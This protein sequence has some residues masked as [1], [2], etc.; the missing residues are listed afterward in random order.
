MEVEQVTLNSNELFSQTNGECNLNGGDL[1]AP[2]G[3]SLNGGKLNGSGNIQGDVVNDG[4]IVSPGHSPGAIT[5]SGNYTQTANGTLNLQIAGTARRNAIRPTRHHGH[6][7]LAGTLNLE[8]LNGFLPKD[9][10]NFQLLTYYNAVGTWANYTGFSPDPNVTFTRTQTPAYFIATAHVVDVTPPTVSIISPSSSGLFYKTNPTVSGTAADESSGSGLASDD[11]SDVSLRCYGS[12]GRILEWLDMGY[13]YNAA[14]HER[15]T[16]G[17][18]ASWTFTL[19]TLADGKYY[20]RATAKDKTGNKA[21]S[22]S[23]D[24]FVDK[25]IPTALTVTAP[26]ASGWV[27]SLNAI[28]GTATDATNSSGIDNVELILQR[29]SDNKYWA[30][31]G[32]VSNS[33]VIKSQFR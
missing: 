15:A 30:D 20:V 5:I 2:N 32:W 16:S 4:G 27:K 12:Y 17:T 25:T 6:R 19:P 31:T 7:L 26:T 8:M 21:A 28:L 13:T 18:P 23:M 22:P 29:K 14:T 33:Q 24:F 11:D 10:D 9:G 3:V 1:V